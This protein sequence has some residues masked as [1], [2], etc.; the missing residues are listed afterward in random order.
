MSNIIGDTNDNGVLD[1][2]YELLG[3]VETTLACSTACGEVII[4]II[5]LIIILIIIFFFF[6]FL[7][8]FFFLFL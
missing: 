7:L 2:G 6:F 3:N 4:I 8:L 5:I 1:S